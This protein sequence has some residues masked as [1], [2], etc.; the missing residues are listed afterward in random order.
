MAPVREDEHDLAAK[1]GR[2][3]LLVV[4]Q[5]LAVVLAQIRIHLLGPLDHGAAGHVVLA[6][7]QE[8]ENLVSA[9]SDH[10]LGRQGALEEALGELA[11]RLRVVGA[12]QRLKEL[13]PELPLQ[14]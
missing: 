4:E 6:L 7:P 3:V 12:Y 11:N 10:D 13:V 8:A 9:A 5:V 2:N 1:S 14:M